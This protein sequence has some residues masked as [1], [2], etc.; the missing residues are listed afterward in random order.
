MITKDLKFMKP[1]DWIGVK[2]NKYVIKEKLGRG[3]KG[4]VFKVMDTLED[5][6]K[7]VKLIPAE[8]ADSPIAFKE[9]K[10]EVNNASDIIHPNVVK[11]IGL[12]NYEGQYF[13]VM[14]YI[15]GQSLEQIL[16]DSKEGRLKEAEVIEIMKKL[17]RG[18]Q[19]VHKK[20]VIHRDI[21]PSNL[22]LAADGQFKILD[23]GISYQITK[24]MTRLAGELHEAGTW[25]YMAPEQLSTRY[26]REN[27]QVDVWGFGVTM[28]QL[29]TGELPFSHKDQIKDKEEKPYE[30][31]GVSR[32]TR[33][34]VMR[35]LEKDRA[36]RF[37]D[38]AE[39]LEALSAV[40]KVIK[41]TEKSQKPKLKK[42]KKT[43]E[44]SP[45]KWLW[46][47]ASL[48]VVIGL[49]VIFNQVLK[50]DM[51]PTIKTDISSVNKDDVKYTQYLKQAKDYLNEEDFKKARE[52]L[53]LAKM[54]KNTKD[55]RDI[56]YQIDELERKENEFS[57]YL[58]KARAAY[59]NKDY[60]AALSHIL[61][62]KKIKVTRDLRE[63]EKNILLEKEEERKKKLA[64]QDAQDWGIAQTRNTITAYQEYLAKHKSGKYA[65]K[66][67]E[68]ISEL[69]KW[70]DLPGDV[71][72]VAAKIGKEKVTKNDKYIWEADFGDGIVMVYIPAGEFTMGQ[73][74]EEKRWL[75]KK[76][77]QKD[78]DEYYKDE[79]PNHKVF[80]DGYWLGKHEVT[81]KQFQK[82]VQ[83]S[84]YKTQAE[85]EDGAYTWT[86]K[87][88]E[89]R[90]NIN[91]KT[92]GFSQD[93]NNPVV[94]I[95]WHDAVEYCRW[96]SKDKGL[97][98][99]LPT[100]A[101]WEKASRGA[102]SR[103]YPWGSHDPFYKDQWYGNY[104][105][106]DSWEKRGEDGYEYTAPVGS[107]PAGASPYGLLDMAGNVWE[108]CSDWYKSDYYKDSPTENPKGPS[109]GS[110]R[111]LRGGSWDSDAGYVRCACRT[112]LDPANRGDFVGFR[113][114][115]DVK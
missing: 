79:T 94:C 89:K 100:E 23:F 22:M 62:A 61:K 41:K 37:K 57:E 97:K 80:L 88:W 1:E 48:V 12:E 10:R 82:F 91:W 86:G 68:K 34:I 54:I 8:I 26:G 32:P 98:F 75:I 45:K 51:P 76:L 103:K 96:L 17:A 71:K 109:S 60:D 115:Q 24:S 25:P 3:G 4:I 36:S 11:V 40:S 21:K 56:E 58:S 44:K 42:K 5:K 72:K 64:K 38:M 114:A 73:T 55:T 108:W 14:E 31:E 87:K 18:L 70:A 95:S 20:K 65:E 28:Y 99:N 85:K 29:L 33:K 113:L 90:A 27:E 106:N 53:N 111:V 59:N 69:K 84:G 49:V 92:P 67:R 66:A 50:R 46:A 43:S 107:Y 47:A 39:V 105:A 63:L 16:A 78:Y 93:E 83:D 74:D 110:D 13:I 30:L 112:G 101:Q 77:G 35:C 19:E 15:D 102:D 104:A 7:A 81:V 52:N 6:P 2:F 9:L